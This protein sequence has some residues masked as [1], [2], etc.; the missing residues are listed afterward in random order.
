MYDTFG[1]INNPVL[2]VTKSGKING[3]ITYSKDLMESFVIICT[4]TIFLR[5]Y[6]L[7]SFISRKKKLEIWTFIFIS[8]KITRKI[9]GKKKYN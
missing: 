8:V 3:R 6:D 4:A 7:F 5:W 1:K 2:V 9:Y